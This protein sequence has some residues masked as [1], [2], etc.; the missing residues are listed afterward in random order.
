[1]ITIAKGMTGGYTTMAGVLISDDIRKVFTDQDVAFLH[2]F[3]M[4]ANPV[5]CV[6]ATTVIDIIEQEGLVERSARLGEYLQRQAQQK[7]ARHPSVGDV[8]GK[9]MLLGVELVKDRQSKEPFDAALT[10]AYRLYEI[11]KQKGCMIYPGGG[12]IHGTKGDHFLASPPLIITEKEIDTALDILEET[13]TELE[14]EMG[15]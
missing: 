2:G 10:V 15:M 11:A 3:T 7:L 9:G 6:A 5:S 13:I 8:R 4:E 1:M 12:I 14:H